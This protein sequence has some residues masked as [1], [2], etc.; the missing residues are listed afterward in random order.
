MKLALTISA[1]AASALVLAGP[2]QSEK[3]FKAR[4]TVQTDLPAT[5]D[6][7]TLVLQI[8]VPAG[9]WLIQAKTQAV[10][11]GN[12]DIVRCQLN[13]GNSTVLDGS[14]T[15]V[16][17]TSGLPLVAMLVNQAVTK[18]TAATNIKFLCSHSETAQSG[19]YLDPGSSLI[20]E[21]VT[22]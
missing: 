6:A 22:P 8:S 5:K 20:I 3:L 1:I 2:A 21:E 7:T 16:G 15:Q 4:T 11:F 14:G 10:N 9:R 19:I 18:T 17:S 13:K 12:A